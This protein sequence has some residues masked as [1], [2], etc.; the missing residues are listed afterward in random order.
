MIE[1]ITIQGFQAHDKLTISLDFGVTTIVGASD[2]GKSSIIRAIRWL[3]LNLPSGDSFI[4]W[5]EQRARVDAKVDGKFVLRERGT[6]NTYVL[7]TR[8]FKAFGNGGVPEEITNLLGISEINFQGQYDSPFWLSDTA[9]EVSRHLNRIVGLEIIDD[10]L[11][12]LTSLIRKRSTEVEVTEKRLD[13]AREECKDWKFAKDVDADLAVLEELELSVTRLQDQT[14]RL[15]KEID[16]YESI[17]RGTLQICMM[18]S[19]GCGIVEDGEIAE[20][21]TTRCKCLRNVICDAEKQQSFTHR[22]QFIPDLEDINT[23]QKLESRVNELGRLIR[24]CKQSV[25]EETDARGYVRQML[26]EWDKNIGKECPLCGQ[27]IEH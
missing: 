23:V 13:D 5:G 1:N 20:K 27:S 11:S 15:S 18:I 2:V 4:R 21:L 3:A 19:I 16:R 14:L 7:D 8:E 10:V 24:A 22:R 26:K 12:K 25:Y 17:D 9:G 6:E